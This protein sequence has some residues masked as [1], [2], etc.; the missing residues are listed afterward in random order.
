MDA[1]LKLVGRQPYSERRLQERLLKMGF[2]A[3]EIAAC[4]ERMN[5]WGYLNDRAYGVARIE[6]L[7]RRLKSRAYVEADLAAEGLAREL[8]AE[9]LSEQYSAAE[10]IAIARSLLAKLKRP[11]AGPPGVKECQKLARAGFAEH[12][13][14]QCLP[15]ISSP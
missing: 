11:G 2:A 10:E 4:L 6:L 7:K 5:G 8:I 3:A 9:V 12:T 1:A 15:E 14:R 13:I